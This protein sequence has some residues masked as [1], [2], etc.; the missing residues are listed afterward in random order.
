MPATAPSLQAVL[1]RHAQRG[2]DENSITFDEFAAHGAVLR[3]DGGHMVD[4]AWQPRLAEGMVRCYLV[5]DR[6]AGFGHQ[7]VNALCPRPAR[8][9]AK[10]RRPGP[11]STTLP[12]CRT[13]R[14]EAPLETQ[15]M[16]QLQRTLD[17]DARG[18]PCCGTAISCSAS[19]RGRSDE[20]RYVLCEIN[21]SSVAPFP[22][23]AIEPLVTATMRSLR[24]R[25]A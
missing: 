11:G 24:G 5:Q 6:V 25:A 19:R 2:S 9:E 13:S 12:T 18:C 4:Q 21:V 22:A 10:R 14:P 3:A 7:A 8:V 23:S 17:I 15:W 16:P 1:V 20:E